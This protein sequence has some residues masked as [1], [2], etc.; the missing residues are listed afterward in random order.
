MDAAFGV[1]LVLCSYSG[2]D[3]GNGS[4][5]LGL[6]PS[7]AEQAWNETGGKVVGAIGGVATTAAHGVAE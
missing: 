1:T 4:D 7:W 6:W 3:P 5:P 2:D